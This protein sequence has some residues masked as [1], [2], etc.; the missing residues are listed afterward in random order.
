VYSY[1]LSSVNGDMAADLV[2]EALVDYALVCRTATLDCGPHP[3]QSVYSALATEVA[4]DRALISL[5]RANG[6]EV[7]ESRF[8]HPGEE[9]DRLERALA[10][11]GT[12]LAA[13]T[14]IREEP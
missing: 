12:D 9:R 2:G 14:R 6:V 4:Y 11:A 8:S 1:L 3:G 7:I 13:L 5:C 10:A